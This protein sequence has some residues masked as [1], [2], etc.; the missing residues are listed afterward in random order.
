MVKVYKCMICEEGYIGDDAPTHC[1]FCGAHRN[2]L[3]QTDKYAVKDVGE[4][5]A[6]SKNNLVGA[7]DVEVSNAEFYFCAAKKADNVADATMFKRLAKIEAEHASTIAKMLNV[8]SPS[9]SRDKD[10]CQLGSL[11]NLKESHEREEAAIKR[12]VQFLSEAVETKVKMLF[13]ALIEI[14]KDHL[15]LSD[16]RF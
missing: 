6:V 5:S 7:L 3:V 4:L 9:I 1:P 13:K 15:S 10:T 11:D 12:Y 16:G 2:Y 14:E 8:E